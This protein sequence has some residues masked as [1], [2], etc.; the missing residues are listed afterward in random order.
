MISKRLKAVANFINKSDQVVD[1]ACDHGLLDI[2][3]IKHKNLNNIIVSDINESAL[4]NAVS[5]IEKY[6]LK[7]NIFPI[8][9]DGLKN[10]DIDKKDTIIISGLGTKTII[11]ILRNIKNLKNIKKLV[12]QANNDHYYLRSFLTKQNFYIN[13]E[14][15]V[16]DV[17]KSYITIEFLRGKKRYSYKELMYGPVLIK[18]KNNKKYFEEIFNQ[19]KIIL[20]KIPENQK[21]ERNIIIK[22]IKKL[23]KIISQ[24]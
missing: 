23:N 24:H 4:N 19:L 22:K 8:L 15:V 17:N 5:N 6:N 2:Y 16:N 13:N 18:N 9:S 21:F 1:V 12:I 3:L 14:S 11:K 10:I 20:D 7:D